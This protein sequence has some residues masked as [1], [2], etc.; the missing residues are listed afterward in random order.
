MELD[1]GEDE[2]EGPE[3]DIED[4]GDANEEMNE[5]AQPT[6]TFPEGEAPEPAPEDAPE[7]DQSLGGADQGQN[8]GEGAQDS[9]SSMVPE[10]AAAESSIQPGAEAEKG[11]EEEEKE[12]QD[13][14]EEKDGQAD[15]NDA[16]DDDSDPSLTAPSNAADGQTKQRSSAA[17]P[18]SDPSKP[19]PNQ[20]SPSEPQRSLGDALQSWKRRLEAI[21]DLEEAE[22]DA[23]EPEKLAIGEEDGEVEF[24]QD[25]DET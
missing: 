2:Q 1:L 14:E 10:T 20:P 8:G 4:T 7:L 21:S 13:K 6:E 11:D 5:D 9:A 3:H 18:T 15:E 24:V 17:D 23:T 19:R 12:G 22:P 16:M 25:G